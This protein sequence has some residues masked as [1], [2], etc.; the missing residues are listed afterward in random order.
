MRC[1]VTRDLYSLGEQK[2][3][4]VPSSNQF[5]E[6]PGTVRPVNSSDQFRCNGVDYTRSALA[7]QLD[8]GI[9]N[10][11]VSGAWAEKYA[12]LCRRSSPGYHWSGWYAAY[13]VAR[14]DGKTPEAAAKEG[15]VHIEAVR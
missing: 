10:T 8:D 2:L 5:M 14:Q 3:G 1:F 11:F 4:F 13:L 6:G 7:D 9:G 15:K 12:T